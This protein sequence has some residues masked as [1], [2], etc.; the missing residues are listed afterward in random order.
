M[1]RPFSSKA[2]ANYFLEKSDPPSE[3]N[4]TQMKLH[5]LV[6]FAHG[7][8]L[9][10]CERPL[11]RD[12]IQAW[13]YGPVIPALY[14]EFKE[15]G[16]NVITR[17]A[18][19][20]S[21]I[22]FDYDDTPRIEQPGNCTKVVLDWVWDHYGV[23]SAGQLSTLTHENGGPWETTRRKYGDVPH[24]EISDEVIEAYFKKQ[25]ES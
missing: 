21:F 5:K 8:S 4:L 12:V 13:E 3:C 17:P 15:F 14:Q 6:Y 16:A 25:L 10:V 19:E 24:V 18:K 9:A 11:I 1:Y 22:T 7:I 20:F 23:L 2:V